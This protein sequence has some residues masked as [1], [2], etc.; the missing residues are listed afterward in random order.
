MHAIFLC[1]F[2]HTYTHTHS[3]GASH[4]YSHVQIR[5]R[6][7]AHPSPTSGF[8]WSRRTGKVAGK[9]WTLQ[10]P[11]PPYLSCLR[12][13]LRQEVGQGR[14]RHKGSRPSLPFHSLAGETSPSLPAPLPD[15]TFPSLITPPAPRSADRFWNPEL[16]PILPRMRVGRLNPGERQG[17]AAWPALP[18]PAEREGGRRLS[19]A[20]A[21]RAGCADFGCLFPG[22]WQKSPGTAPRP[23]EVRARTRSSYSGASK[24][25]TVLEPQEHSSGC[26]VFFFIS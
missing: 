3:P 14:R 10:Y 12:S 4:T 15:Q 25:N 16:S 8:C 2:G 22:Q 5:T 17:G 21:R 18:G 13:C 11:S 26:C 23:S 20:R 24:K 19:K 1:T 6:A 7:A 9:A